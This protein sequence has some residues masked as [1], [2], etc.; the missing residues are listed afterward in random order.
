MPKRKRVVQER[1]E[2]WLR[3]RRHLKW[4]EHVL[5]EL[6]R[7]VVVFGEMA[8]DRARA[9]GAT[10]RT[11]DRAADRFDAA[12]MRGLLPSDRPAAQDGDLRTLA[13]PIRQR[14]VNLRAEVPSMSLREIALIGDCSSGAARPIIRSNGCSLL[15]RRPQSPVADFHPSP[16]WQSPYAGA[17]PLCSCTPRGGEC[18]RSH[19][20]W[21]PRSGR[22][23]VHSSAGLLS[24]LPV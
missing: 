20:I 9:T 2:T 23:I 19:G 12:G 17:L 6:V 11:I 8:A 22:S 4:P 13:P 7:P 24:S 18:R 10:E 5:Y 3:L 21:R 1:T 16:T 15:D 14:I